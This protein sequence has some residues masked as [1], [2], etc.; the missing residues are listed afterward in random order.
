[1]V[2]MDDDTHVPHQRYNWTEWADGRPRV[3]ERGKDFSC[4]ATSF[5][6]IA[7]QYA[8]RN[9]LKVRTARVGMSEPERVKI[10]FFK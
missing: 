4:T 2:V 3:L 6:S 1:M 10:R 5:Q 9:G 8:K 7:R